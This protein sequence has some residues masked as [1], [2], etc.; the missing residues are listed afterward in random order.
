MT[1]YVTL[2]LGSSFGPMCSSFSLS[3]IMQELSDGTVAVLSLLCRYVSMRNLTFSTSF[4]AI[5]MQN[6]TY[7]VLIP[8]SEHPKPKS[9][10]LPP[11]LSMSFMTPVQTKGR[12][13]AF[14]L[15]LSQGMEMSMT[16]MLRSELTFSSLP[17]FPHLPILSHHLVTSFPPSCDLF[18]SLLVLILVVLGS[19]THS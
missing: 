1:S 16:P 18:D 10:M 17:T 13:K 15:F 6:P 12:Q 7:E 11:A 19:L 8:V 14:W 4:F 3:T 5:I 9:F 2:H